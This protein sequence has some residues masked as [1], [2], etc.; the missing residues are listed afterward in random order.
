VSFHLLNLYFDR[1]EGLAQQLGLF[2]NHFRHLYGD[3]VGERNDVRRNERLPQADRGAVVTALANVF[4]P[5]LAEIV[6]S[7]IISGP[8]SVNTQARC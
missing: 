7:N 6:L 2:R 1:V 5:S 8:A 4:G 3:K